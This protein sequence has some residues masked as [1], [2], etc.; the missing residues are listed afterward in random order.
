MANVSQIKLPNGTTYDIKDSVSGYITD[1][2]VTGVKGN[3]ETTYRTGQ[4]NLT[5][6]NIG[7]VAKSGDTMTGLLTTKGNVY[8]DA[9]TGA[10]NLANSNIYGVNSIYTA[11]VSDDSK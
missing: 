4:V 3:A 8:D 6:A 11:D 10:L 1:A 2:G 7:A 5:S 9:Y